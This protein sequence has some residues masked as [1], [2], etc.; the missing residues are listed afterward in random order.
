MIVVLKF[1]YDLCD[2]YCDLMYIALIWTWINIHLSIY[3]LS[4]PKDDLFGLDI[5]NKV[6]EIV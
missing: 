2:N 6:L 3:Y 4:L 5:I 1:D